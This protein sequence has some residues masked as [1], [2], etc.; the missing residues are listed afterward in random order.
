[1]VIRMFLRILFA[2]LFTVSIFAAGAISNMETEIDK[3][4]QGIKK[5]QNNV[6]IIKKEE[7][8]TL[9]KLERIEKDLKRIKE[10]YYKVQAEYI[11]LTRKVEYGEK[12]IKL[13][14]RKADE[15]DEH[16]REKLLLW[17]KYGERAQFEYLISGAN[18]FDF[19]DRQENLT[20]IL[21]NDRDN[22]NQINKLAENIK[23]ETKRINNKKRE[24]SLVRKELRVKRKK[25]NKKIKE[26]NQ[27]LTALNKKE[28]GVNEKISLL[29]KEQIRIRKRI[30]K[31]IKNRI[32]KVDKKDL[33]TA[34]KDLGEM[35]YPLK[36]K[37]ILDF[38]DK[39]EIAY[40]AVVKSEGMEIQSN[41]GAR[42]KAATS[43]EVVFSAQFEDLGNMV[44]INHGSGVATVYG[45]MI[46]TYVK[47]GDQVVKGQNIGV[48]GL[49]K[50]EREPRLYFE[51]RFNTKSID[52]LIFL[53]RK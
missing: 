11:A 29:K 25:L 17:Y 21:E 16:M 12:N 34:L 48:L 7:S 43:G 14:K 40:G 44:I 9:K 49:S 45:N 4:K 20:L 10:D 32:K 39:K 18:L 1:M 36:G 5:E 26:K 41:L 46:T 19:F 33:K 13:T 15:K 3:I 42:I 50:K 37:V 6:K 2:F 35:Q 51:I 22:I 38:A 24:T 30:D 31:I 28:V 23:M 47:R 8:K 52:P 53:E 27:L